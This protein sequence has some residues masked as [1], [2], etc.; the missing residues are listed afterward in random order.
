MFTTN[1][2]TADRV[3]RLIAGAVVIALG[4]LYSNWFGLAGVV[5]MGTAFLRW[6][7]AYVPFKI[8]TCAAQTTSE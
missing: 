2:G 5:L 7:P 8:S 4:L 3:V 6:C 1:V